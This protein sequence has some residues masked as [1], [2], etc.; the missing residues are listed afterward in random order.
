MKVLISQGLD[1]V[2]TIELKYYRKNK[3]NE[4][5]IN[6]KPSRSDKV[7]NNDVRVGV[8]SSLLKT[9]TY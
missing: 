3:K 7:R 9:G 1:G 5:F 4:S 6:Q 8:G 2:F